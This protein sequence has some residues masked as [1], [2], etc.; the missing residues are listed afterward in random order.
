MQSVIHVQQPQVAEPAAL[1]HE[2]MREQRGVHATAEGKRDARLAACELDQFRGGIDWKLQSQLAAKVVAMDFNPFARKRGW[3]SLLHK[4]ALSDSNPSVATSLKTPK[5]SMRSLRAA[6][7]LS[8]GSLSSVPRCLS[9]AVLMVAA[10][11]PHCGARH[12]RV[13][14][15]LRRP[16]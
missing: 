4:A 11:P 2:E 5:L 10:T 15:A 14:A 16:A 8:G 9:N 1:L 6:R 12:R 3:L 7:N 13:P